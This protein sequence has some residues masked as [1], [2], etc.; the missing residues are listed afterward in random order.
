MNEWANDHIDNQYLGFEAF[1]SGDLI[2]LDKDGQV[3]IIKELGRGGRTIVYLCEYNQKQYALKWFTQE[4]PEVFYQNLKSNLQNGV[5]NASKSFLW[6]LMLTKKQNNTFGYVMDLL[7]SEYRELGDYLLGRAKYQSVSAIVNAAIILSKGFQDLSKDNYVYANFNDDCL[8]IH[9]ETGDVIFADTDIIHKNNINLG[10]MGKMRYIAPETL[11]GSK[12]DHFSNHFSL[13]VVLFLIFFNNHPLEGKRHLSGP[14]MSASFERKIYGTEPIFIFDPKIDLN[15][16]VPNVH[17]NSIKL[18]P[19][20]PSLLR[21]TFIQTFSQEAIKNPSQRV[22]PEQW[23]Q[24]LVEARNRLVADD[25]GNQRFL[26]DDEKPKAAL[27]SN[28]GLIAL[29]VG[30]TIFVGFSTVPFAK[31]MQNKTEPDAWVLKN[32]SNHS[33]KVET[34]SGKIKEVP[35]NELMPVKAGLKISCAVN[36]TFEVVVGSELA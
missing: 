29:V 4:L 28:D 1:K 16:P 19:L 18:W 22:T 20:Y 5:P 30:K 25:N 7:P 11:L 15:R 33:W 2:D 13:S 14:L 34:I 10:I 17:K 27:K 21:N 26:E 24:I 9:P 31:V 6:P 8:Y 35:P 12:P 36:G 23:L 3:K 32:I